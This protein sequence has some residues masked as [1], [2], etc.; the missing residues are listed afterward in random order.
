VSRHHRIAIIGAGPY[1]LA[2]AAELHAAKADV[3]LF[4]RAMSFW[5]QSVAKGTRLLTNPKRCSFNRDTF[6]LAAHGN[7]IGSRVP[8]PLL[9]DQFI[10]YG[11]WFY[12]S[13]CPKSDERPVVN[14]I[15]TTG[16]YRITTEDGSDTFAE[17]LIVAIGLKSFAVRP[18]EFASCPAD[19]VFHT[20]DLYDLQGFRGKKVAV[21][22]GGQSAIDS[23]A[24]LGEQKANVEVITRAASLFWSSPAGPEL[25][26]HSGG[27]LFDSV[28]AIRGVIRGTLNNPDVFRQ[29]PAS[30]RRRWLKRALRP[31]ASSDLKPRLSAVRFSL[32]R[33]VIAANA[34][35]HRVEL[36][37]DDGSTRSVDR[38]V[39]GTGYSVDIARIRFL[40]PELR[41]QIRECEGNPELH[42][43]MESAVPGLYFAGAAAAWN[44]GPSMWF[45]LGAPWAA[46][47]IR[48][49]LGYK[50]ALLSSPLTPAL[51]ACGSIQ[52]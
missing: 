5:Q 12:R 4:G 22:G 38:V 41:C 9:A 30:V 24:L 50:D 31:A 46:E 7:S 32:G 11:L 21:I 1:G 44:F 35:D 20:S 52:S 13:V 37:L 36:R 17:E 3:V 19:S 33:S 6:D 8:N 40:A 10:D 18:Q 34:N 27:S 45:I 51:A 49:A 16:H 42:G 29:L 23:A 15:R 43:T 47:R 26:G 39:L 28:G 25:P 48:R 14:V 2:L